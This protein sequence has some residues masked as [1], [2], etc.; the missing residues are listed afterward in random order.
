MVSLPVASE[1]G[2]FENL[3]E[4]ADIY[5]SFYVGVIP[6]RCMVVFWLCKPRLER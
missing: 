2:A 6:T 1:E 3:G 4:R 5:K